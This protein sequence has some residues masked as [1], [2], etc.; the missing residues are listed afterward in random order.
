M[1]KYAISKFAYILLVAILISLSIGYTYAYFSAQTRATAKPT[2]GKIS[3]LWRDFEEEAYFTSWFDDVSAIKIDSNLKLQ[4]GDY[5]PIKGVLP[6]ED[7]DAADEYINLSLG[8]SN[9]DATVDAYCRI[10][11]VAKYTPKNTST[12]KDCTPGWVQLAL[13]SAVIT[14]KV[15]N[16]QANTTTEKGWFEHNGYYY[17]GTATKDSEGDIISATLK[18]LPAT[19]TM[20]IANQLYLAG[21]A[22]NEILGSSMSITLILE[23]VQTTNN[24]YQA[25]WG[26][27]W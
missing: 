27:D 19:E 2:L 24:A 25:V 17:Y 18:S 4:R 1:R 21:D 23:G 11:I 5:T 7:E 22:G 16:Q 10:Q 15:E 9:I 8:M 13:N 12:V 26:V 3:I 20:P 14:Q 6:K